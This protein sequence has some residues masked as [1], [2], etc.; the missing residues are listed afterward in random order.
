MG[1]AAVEAVAD[2]RGVEAKRVGGVNAEL[3]RAAGQG[4]EVDEPGAVGALFA[5]HKACDSRFAVF[6]VD[7]LARTVKRI[8]EKGKADLAFRCMMYDV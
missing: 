7:H 3:V 8:R 2:D 6:V 4:E 5:Q 1:L